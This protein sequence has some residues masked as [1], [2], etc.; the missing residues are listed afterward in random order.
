MLVPHRGLFKHTEHGV[1]QHVLHLFPT[2][3]VIYGE[4]VDSPHDLS[5]RFSPPKYSLHFHS[6]TQ[7]ILPRRV[8]FLMVSPPGS[9]ACKEQGETATYA[10]AL[11]C[12]RQRS[13]LVYAFCTSYAPFHP[14]KTSSASPGSNCSRA[15]A[16]SLPSLDIPRTQLQRVSCRLFC[17]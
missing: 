8:L 15:P 3:T 6:Q 11:A 16:C 4:N 7:N 1:Q 9:L 2:W 17:D 5:G 14:C 13:L 10:C 12:S